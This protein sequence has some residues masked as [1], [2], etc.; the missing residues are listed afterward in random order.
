MCPS[1]EVTILFLL[2]LERLYPLCLF[3]RVF[4]PLGRVPLCSIW[5]YE[6]KVHLE[7]SACNR[8]A[9][10]ITDYPSGAGADPHVHGRHAGPPLSA[11][12]TEILCGDCL[13]GVRPSTLYSLL[14]IVT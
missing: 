12:G 5:L 9:L 6:Y 1:K 11:L 4:S 2:P 14:F 10:E 8:E 3:R 13:L 7:R